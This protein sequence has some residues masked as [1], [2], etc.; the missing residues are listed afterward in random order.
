MN[1]IAALLLFLACLWSDLPAQVGADFDLFGEE[2]PLRMKLVF[3]Y[4]ALVKKKNQEPEYQDAELTIYP[5]PTDSITRTIRV[6]A[7]GEFRRR[8]CS[9]PPIRFNVE[10]ADFGLPSLTDQG[11]LKVVT[12]C[13]DQDIYQT[14]LYREYMAYKLYNQ[15]TDK[16]FRVRMLDITYVDVRGKKAPF[17]QHGFIIEDDD[18]VAARNGCIVFK[19]ERMPRSSLEQHQLTLAA[20][21]NYMIGNTDW[22]VGNL[23]NVKILRSANPLEPNYYVVPYDFDYSGLVDTHYAVPN[24]QLGIK[25]VRQRL[26]RSTCPTEEELDLV[27]DLFRQQKAAIFDQYTDF[28]YLREA[29]K[30]EALDYLDSFYDIINDPRRVKRTIL[31]DCKNLR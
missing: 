18:Q 23:H 9:F 13:R 10:D 31:T 2:T 12:T 11:K 7:R 26:F 25:S 20:V 5:T 8:Y 3:D 17:R 27:L 24:E 28:P 4:K 6:K 1:R 29:D 21:F 14:Y 15:L 22:A 19:P 16:S 30:Q